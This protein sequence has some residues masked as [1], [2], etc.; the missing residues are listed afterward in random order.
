MNALR[1]IGGWIA[2]PPAQA[3]DGRDQWPSRMSFL[4]AAMGGCAGMGNLLRYPSQVYNNHGL[5]WYIPYLM[6]VF[7]IAIPV[8]V[9]EIAIGNA[10]R[11]GSVVAYNSMNWRLKG[12]GLSLLYVAFL[13][14]PY[15]VA[16]LSWIMIYFRHSFSKNLPWEGNA[17]DF[18]DNQV[19]RNP[20]PIMGNLSEDNSRVENYTEYPAV[21]LI[22]ETVGWACFT[23]FLV[24]VSIFRG[25]GLTGRVV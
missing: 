18:F 24:W 25:V 5:Q 14:T 2:P 8:L 19:I 12:L 6:A 3:A 16:N 20:V 21:G 15:F 7:L 13:V 1:K 22:G 4:L 17:Q 23:W 11:A 9:L 10:Y